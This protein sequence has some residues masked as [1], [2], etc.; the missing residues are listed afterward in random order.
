MNK[1]DYLELMYIFNHHSQKTMII[2]WPNGLKV[3]CNAFHGM[4]ESSEDDANDEGGYYTLVNEVRIL[5][6]GHDDSVHIE[7]DLIE[8]SLKCI[9]QKIELEDGTYLWQIQNV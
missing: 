6:Y 4:A 2:T 7:N 9:P 3:K 5:E 1:Q 8:I